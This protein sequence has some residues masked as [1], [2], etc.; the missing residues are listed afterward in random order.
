M[1][2]PAGGRV[3]MIRRGGLGQT[4]PSAEQLQGVTDCGDPCQAGY[5][6]CAAAVPGVPALPIGMPG[7][8]TFSSLATP[9]ISLPAV[10][11]TSLGTALP[12]ILGGLALVVLGGALSGK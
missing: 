6:A 11:S 8:G 4:C 7:S 12:W 5:G 10:T 1:Y 3:R 2:V 9:Q